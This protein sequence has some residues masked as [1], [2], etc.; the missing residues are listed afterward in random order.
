MKQR[1][2]NDG[3]IRETLKYLINTTGTATELE[4]CK[5]LTTLNYRFLQND[6]GRFLR[7]E[8]VSNDTEFHRSY[9]D[10]SVSFVYSYK[11]KPV[12]I[13]KTTYNDISKLSNTSSHITG[14]SK[15]IGVTRSE[16]Y[17]F[18]NPLFVDAEKLTIDSLKHFDD[19]HWV[20][21]NVNN[22]RKKVML[23]HKDESSDHV[24]TY[25][26]RTY[27]M[28]MQDIRCIRLKNYINKFIL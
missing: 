3:T 23:V 16:A 5:V 9:D 11:S 27:N 14:K 15:F 7:K 6:I 25:Y 18:L 1:K 22:R 24:R 10:K 28:K 26:A 2:L 21:T 4:I 20:I 17:V 12:E 19:R 8:F 13:Q